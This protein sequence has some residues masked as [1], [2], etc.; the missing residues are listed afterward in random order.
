MSGAARGTAN[1]GGRGGGG[2]GRGGRGGRIF[3]YRGGGKGGRGQ[4]GRGGY[5]K[6][7]NARGVFFKGETK[8]M[9][10][11]VFQTH[12]EQKKRGQFQD[13]MDALKVYSS[14]VYKKDIRY[15]NPLFNR[16]ERP[17][18][19]EPEQNFT[20]TE[21]TNEHGVITITQTPTHFE[22]AVYNERIKTWIKATDAL[23]ST[24]RS[25][26]NIV[27]GQCSNLMQN[28]IKASEKYEERDTNG[29]VTWLLTEIRSISHQLEA[30]V[31]LYDSV[32]EAK[33]AYYSYKQAPEDSN[34]T[35]LKNYKTNVDVVK[36]FGS[37]LFNDEALITYEQ[38][39]DK[40]E[41]KA[42][43]SD[44]KY[45]ERV[46]DKMMGVALLKR[47]D[48]ERY[49]ELKLSIRD[50]FAFG[51][52]VYPKTLNGAYDLLENHSASRNLQPRRKHT[53]KDKD[54]DRNVKGEEEELQG[55]QF[56]QGGDDEAVAGDDGRLKPWITCHKCN[57]KGH[58]SDHCPTEEGVQQHNQGSD[59]AGDNNDTTNSEEAGEQMHMDGTVEEGDENSGENTE[60][61]SDDESVIMDFQFAMDSIGLYDDK[62]ILI[63]TGSTFSVMK[64]PKMVIDI[65]KS[66]KVMKAETNGGVQESNYKALLPGFFE[67]W[68]NTKSKFN[69]LSWADVRKKFRITSDTDKEDSINVHLSRNKIMKFVEISSGLYI[70]RPKGVVLDEDKN[71]NK[72]ISAYS[73]LNLVSGNKKHFSA[74]QIAG[75]E[76]SRDLF[77]KL[78]MPGYKKYFRI[79]EKNQIRNCRV[80]IDDAKVS[81]HIFGREPASIKGKAT[82]QRPQAI[83][84]IQMV[85]IPSTILD[86]HP[87][88]MLSMDY[89]YIQSIPM[90][91]TISR[92]YKFRT[93]EAVRVKT[94]TKRLQLKEP[95]E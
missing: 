17:D 63:D 80:T 62:A 67:V 68:F 79:L 46:R 38:N 14:T 41:G 92:G 74:R 72:H 23:D 70:W 24:L 3:K 40:T 12:S 48:E 37:D 13:T 52:D 88:V 55:M 16:L 2:G 11:N 7:N 42:I 34:A 8:E 22:T 9:N 50:Q 10:G 91:H 31:S 58:Y 19:S 66:K 54:E 60:D 84:A 86:L 53:P 49:A 28:K 35:H 76:R 15:L 45:A 77:N 75:A 85:E 32:D 83:G 6:P 20:T 36:H 4:S 69:I 44:E 87:T 59:E 43:D 89:V 25:L 73:F 33:K 61:S 21:N 51:I 65:K 78:G 39:K 1:A 57:K 30:N 94:P 29:D 95:A 93:I 64:N 90:L 5:R 81:M 71:T 26:H 27:R 47:A 18:V 56:A 82:R